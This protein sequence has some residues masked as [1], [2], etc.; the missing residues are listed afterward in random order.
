M[1]SFF[2]L[3]RDRCPLG[4]H[5]VDTFKPNI[6]PCKHWKLLIVRIEYKKHLGNSVIDILNLIQLHGIGF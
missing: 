3:A 6:S 4:N 1:L 5:D 2:M